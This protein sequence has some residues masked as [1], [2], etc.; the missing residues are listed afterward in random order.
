MFA[1]MRK[2]SLA[3]FLLVFCVAA[4]LCSV[5]SSCANIIPP[6]GGPRDSL[7]PQLLSVNPKDSTLNFRGDR[8]TFT[9]DEY[10]DDPQDLSNN[11]IFTPT[12]EQNPDIM[13][14]SR[15][16]T[17][18]FR[19]SLLPNTTYTLNFGN[20]IRDVNEGNVIR[21]FTYTFSTGSALDSLTL[22]GKVVLAENGRTDSTLI[23]MLHRN[24]TDSAVITQRPVYFT[25]LDAAGNFRFRNLPKGTFAIYALGDAGTVRRY[26]NPAQQAFAFANEPVVIGDTTNLTLYAYKARPAATAT[27]TTPPPARGGVAANDRR[28]RFTMGAGSSSLDL[29]SDF[30]LSFASPLRSFDSTK[31]SLS[32]DTT[33][34]P[35]ARYTASLD[36][37]RTVLR[38]RSAWQEGTRHNLILNRDF[39]ED[40]AGRKLLKTDTLNF[41]TKSRSDY[42]QINIRVRNLASIT[43]PVLLFVQNDQ[44]VTAAPLTGGVYRSALFTPGEYELRILS[45]ANRNGTWDPGSFFGTKRQPEIVTPLPRKLVVKAGMEN[46]FDVSL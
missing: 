35:V 16:M 44:V 24:L 5:T 6:S 31:I 18:R 7:P 9:F 46:D 13:V 10:I 42:G 3:G 11:V 26:Q 8:I 28:L 29:Q 23:V 4:Y 32:T 22:S 30:T 38:I 41:T 17:L 14:R 12:F 21:N 27:T 15:T 43:N 25:R 45:D 20:A 36:S 40:S 39:A 34:R 33:F 1:R 37:S 2:P 19:D